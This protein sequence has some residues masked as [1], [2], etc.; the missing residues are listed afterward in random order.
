M[1]IPTLT[2]GPNAGNG[3]LEPIYSKMS[4]PGNDEEKPQIPNSPEPPPPPDA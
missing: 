4:D 3:G 2:I 1:L